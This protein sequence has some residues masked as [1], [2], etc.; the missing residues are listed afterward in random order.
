MF[1]EVS[2]NNGSI[3]NTI[4]IT[5]Q[6]DKFSSVVEDKD[7]VQVN[8]VPAG[9]TASLVL[10]SDTSVLLSLN[11]TALSHKKSDDVYNLEVIFTNNAFEG[12][13]AAEVTNSTRSD[14]SVR[15]NE[16]ASGGGGAPASIK[17]RGVPQ[18]YNN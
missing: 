14:L 2:A 12:G 15:F 13:N 10:K 9:L 18:I 4:T 17:K 11:G 8:R 3:A 1:G 5:V 6:G 7:I 16:G